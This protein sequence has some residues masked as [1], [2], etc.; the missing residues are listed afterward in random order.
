VRNHGKVCLQGYQK[1]GD[2]WVLYV[3]YFEKVLPLP[4]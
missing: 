2:D 4:L 3:S 1:L